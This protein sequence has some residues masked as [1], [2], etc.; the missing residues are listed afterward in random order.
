MAKNRTD[1]RILWSAVLNRL[2][3]QVDEVTS[4]LV[5]EEWNLLKQQGNVTL[6]RE[7]EAP[8]DDGD[9]DGGITSTE[10]ERIKHVAERVS[11]PWLRGE[12]TGRVVGGG[13]GNASGAGSVDVSQDARFWSEMETLQQRRVVHGQQTRTG[14]NRAGARWSINTGDGNNID[15]TLDG[16]EQQLPSPT[17]PHGNPLI[18]T[19][20]PSVLPNELSSLTRLLRRLESRGFALQPWVDGQ[21]QEQPVQ[22][23][24]LK[25]VGSTDLRIAHEDEPP[26]CY[27]LTAPPGRSGDGDNVWKR[28]SSTRSSKRRMSGVGGETGAGDV[29]ANVQ[30]KKLRSSRGSRNQTTADETENDGN[31]AFE[32]ALTTLVQAS[33]G[34]VEPD[35]ANI[36]SS[37]SYPIVDF[38]ESSSGTST[39]SIVQHPSAV[40]Q[41]ASGP[42]TAP[43]YQPTYRLPTQTQTTTS[44]SQSTTPVAINDACRYLALLSQATRLRRASYYSAAPDSATA[45]D[46]SANW[47]HESRVAPIPT[48]NAEVQQ[49]WTNTETNTFQPPTRSMSSTLPTESDSWNRFGPEELEAAAVLRGHNIQRP[50]VYDYE[51]AT[52]M[53]GNPNN[54]MTMTVGT[55]P[56]ETYGSTMTHPSQVYNYFARHGLSNFHAYNAMRRFSNC[57]TV[58]TSSTDDESP[59]ASRFPG[60]SLPNPFYN[61]MHGGFSSG[62]SPNVNTGVSSGYTTAASLPTMI[63]SSTTA[64]DVA[65]EECDTLNQ[66]T[67]QSHSYLESTGLTHPQSRYDGLQH[68]NHCNNL[69]TRSGLGTATTATTESLLSMNNMQALLSGFGSTSGGAGYGNSS[70]YFTP[71][72]TCQALPRPNI[73]RDIRDCEVTID[74]Q[75]SEIRYIPTRRSCENVVYSGCNAG[76]AE[77]ED[78]IE[79][80]VVTDVGQ[81]EVGEEDGEGDEG[82]NEEER[83]IEPVAYENSNSYVGMLTY[84]KHE[85]ENGNCEGP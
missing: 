33:S 73:P 72:A 1:L 27:L 48:D 50:F 69:A 12:G 37:S 49:T 59:V 16:N 52:S 77:V 75:S 43:Q 28:R 38:G 34:F 60:I 78:R 17:S 36:T 2:H 6:L 11:A 51:S 22:H 79:G 84:T 44:E 40:T 15:T 65:N 20:P 32:P 19:G 31:G 5:G 76:G 23:W 4:T 53:S 18:T 7:G 71:T 85:F 35:Y 25:Q 61:T 26:H 30:R 55:P 57:S 56:T 58:S 21:W 46:E 3:G 24:R 83:H 41:M 74:L 70:G 47:R 68:Y 9:G 67:C 45:T 14:A 10:Y 13:G 66:T 64:T 8:G 29:E 39:N 80:K 42:S 54:S 63:P 81:N 62:A 82:Y